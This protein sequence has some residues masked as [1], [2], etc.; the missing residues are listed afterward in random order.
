MEYEI[1]FLDPY[2]LLCNALRFQSAK[3]EEEEKSG[4]IRFAKQQ[5]RYLENWTLCKGLL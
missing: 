5:R 3:N 2:S 4:S 1:N